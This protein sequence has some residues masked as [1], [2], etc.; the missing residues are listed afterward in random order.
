VTA[1]INHHPKSATLAAYAA[2]ALDEA[3][4]VVIATHVE[5]CEHCRRA[6]RD[7]EALGGACLEEIEPAALSEDALQRFWM[8]AGLPSTESAGVSTRAANDSAP[9]GARPLSAYLKG[10]LDAVRWKPFAP[11]MQQSIIAAEGYRRGA[12]RLLKIEPG[13]SMPKHTHKENELTIV[14]RGAYVDELGEFARGDLVDLDDEDTHEPRA[15]GDQPCI[16]LLATSAPLV[17]KNFIGKVVQP[18]IGL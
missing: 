4:S 6:V 18:F 5:I 7:F 16:C 9:E 14:L 13:V 12:L 11:G 15:T 3:R 8:R 2:G 10:G 1:S 17:F